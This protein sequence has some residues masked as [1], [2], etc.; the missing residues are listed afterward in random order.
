MWTIREEKN[1]DRLEEIEYTEVGDPR[2]QYAK[3]NMYWNEFFSIN[4]I[5]SIILVYDLFVGS[6][7]DK[8]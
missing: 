8:N 1:C 7:V 2:M 6:I 5:S 3:S 4:E